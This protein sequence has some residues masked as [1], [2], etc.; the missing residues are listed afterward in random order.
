[1]GIGRL[2]P[3]AGRGAPNQGLVFPWVF[4]RHQEG[5]LCSK[6]WWLRCDPCLSSLPAGQ[7]V[8]ILFFFF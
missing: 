3:R 7:V 2:A 5:K 1:M 4:Q 8:V 6:Q